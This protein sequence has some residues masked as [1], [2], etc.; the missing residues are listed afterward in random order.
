MRTKSL[1]LFFVVLV[2]GVALVF[3]QQQQ[4]P[5]KPAP[6]APP[7][8]APPNQEEP[9]KSQ[10]PIVTH[11]N[12]VDVLFTVRDRR[13]KLVPSLEKQDFKVLDDNA[14]QEIRYFSRQSDLPLRIGML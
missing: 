9:Q 5:A 12:L 6:S 10:T 14:A 3:G 11:V 13:N 1:I 4:N 8:Q 2:S 7:A